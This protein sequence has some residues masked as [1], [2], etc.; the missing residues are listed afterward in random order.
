[1]SNIRRLDILRVL[2]LLVYAVLIVYIWFFIFMPKKIPPYLMTLVPDKSKNILIFGI[3]FNYDEKHKKSVKNGRADTILLCNLNPS[4]KKIT[5]ISFPRDSLVEIPG[6]G[7]HKI[8][9]AYHFSGEKLLAKTIENLLNIKIDNYVCVNLPTFIALVDSLGGV[10][11]SIDNDMYYVDNYGGLKINL[12]KG[13]KKL[14][15]KEAE[16]YVRFRSDKN[17]DIGRIERQKEFLKAVFKKISSPI[18]FIRL[19]F[20]FNT[21]QNKVETD[22]KFS[23]LIRIGNFL[24]TVNNNEIKTLV[25][26]GDFGQGEYF[27]YWILDFP[28]VYNLKKEL[29]L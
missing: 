4:K 6:F 27:G 21:L 14:S 7:Y 18:I 26:P 2:A 13:T 3:D 17:G 28:K 23:E 19:P 5:L 1:M 16:G 10:K 25:I 12:K 22:L 24:R 11:V 9:S 29:Q 8:N 15:G 20:I